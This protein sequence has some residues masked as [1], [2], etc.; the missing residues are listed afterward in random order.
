[1]KRWIGTFL[2]LLLLFSACN[3][4][5]TVPTEYVDPISPPKP[6]VIKPMEEQLSKDEKPNIE[7]ENKQ[8]LQYEQ[9]VFDLNYLLNGIS[10]ENPLELSPAEYVYWACT[11]LEGSVGRVYLEETYH[12]NGLGATIPADLV[13]NLV[14][15][16]FGVSPEYLR[17][18]PSLYHVP[19]SPETTEGYYYETM[20]HMD[21]TFEII[22]ASEHDD[23][24]E[25]TLNNCSDELQWSSRLTLKRNGDRMQYQSHEVLTEEGDN[26]KEYFVQVEFVTGGLYALDN[27]GRLY[28][29]EYGLDVPRQLTEQVEGIATNSLDE[30]YTWTK[31]GILTCWQDRGLEERYESGLWGVKKAAGPYVLQDD[32]NLYFHDSETGTWSL[33]PFKAK[34]FCATSRGPKLVYLDDS[35][36]L[37]C[38]DEY[39]DKLEKIEENIVDFDVFFSYKNYFSTDIWY[40]TEDGSLYCYENYDELHEQYS[41]TSLRGT[42]KDIDVGYGACLLQLQDGSYFMR[43]TDFRGEEMEN[44]FING[45]YGSTR[46]GYYGIIDQ[47]N[48]LHVRYDGTS[49]I[50]RIYSCPQQ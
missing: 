10:W 48:Q 30:V 49:G 35:D 23:L 1:M 28:Y 11:Y 20:Y 4:R 45:I 42:A 15:E 13:E 16:H 9:Y 25:L 37:W 26:E 50:E 6:Q 36:V 21:R 43:S 2:A 40:I 18:D 39:N 27:T 38:Y 34:D 14:A 41:N 7:P 24:L 31:D 17:S 22:D 29:Y 19:L 32:G 8:Y 5:N 12:V 3:Q 44:I 46:A 33:T 47:E